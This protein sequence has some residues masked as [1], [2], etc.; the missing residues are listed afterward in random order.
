[1][2]FVGTVAVNALAQGALWRVTQWQWTEHT[3]F[4]FGGGHSINE[5]LAAHVEKCHSNVDKR[6]R[7][8]AKV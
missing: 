3:T 7:I 8:T 1:M 5:L 2:L 4:E 6:S